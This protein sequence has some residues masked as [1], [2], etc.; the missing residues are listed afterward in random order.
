VSERMAPPLWPLAHKGSYGLSRND[1]QKRGG[2][3]RTLLGLGSAPSRGG[4]RFSVCP[5]LAV[6]SVG[7]S[8]IVAIPPVGARARGTSAPS[9]PVRHHTL[10]C[11]PHLPR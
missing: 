9:P 6:A 2:A 5:R 7:L 3:C 11:C 4:L 10:G 8:H 1:A